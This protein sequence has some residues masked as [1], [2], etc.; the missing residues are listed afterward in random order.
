MSVAHF[1]RLVLR[2]RLFKAVVVQIVQQFVMFG[3]APTNNTSSSQK[4][5]F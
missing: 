1:L 2:R 4:T 3:L 5:P